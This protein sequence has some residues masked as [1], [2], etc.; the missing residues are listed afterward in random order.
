MRVL[1]DHVI[2]AIGEE[3]SIERNRGGLAL[4]LFYD[5]S[6]VFQSLPMVTEERQTYPKAIGYFGAAHPVAI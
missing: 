6:G 1:I 2:E 3:L 4:F 5:Q